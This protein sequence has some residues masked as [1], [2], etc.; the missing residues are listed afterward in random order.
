MKPLYGSTSKEE[1]EE[2]LAETNCVIVY[3]VHVAILMSRSL[4]KYHNYRSFGVS[5]F[6][7][8]SGKST[9]ESRRSHIGRP[10]N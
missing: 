8:V 7:A 10:V 6:G 9:T 5:F 3:L 2:Q 4:F 1:C